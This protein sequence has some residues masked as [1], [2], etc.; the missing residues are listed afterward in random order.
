ME[1]PFSQADKVQML[2]DSNRHLEVE[3]EASREENAML[4]RML[5]GKKREK[6][7]HET[8]ALEETEEQE[9]EAAELPATEQAKSHSSTQ[10]K[11]KRRLSATVTKEIEHLVVP[12]E[13]LQNPLAYTRQ[14]ESSDRISRRLEYVPSHFELHIYR[15]PSFVKN[16]K[17][18]K[19]G[20]DA[21]I[22]GRAAGDTSGLQ[23]GSKHHCTGS[24]Q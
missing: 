13:V 9:K 21:P 16:G 6:L 12:E 5:F 23:Y 20:Q 2:V 7:I 1:L 14:P 22:Y 24:S 3:I 19:A 10:P 17:R 11:R 18:S 8:I 15:M 4:R